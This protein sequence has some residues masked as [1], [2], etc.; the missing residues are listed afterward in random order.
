MIV[1][2]MG[3]SPCRMWIIR[4]GSGVDG[5]SPCRMWIIRNGRG[6]DGGGA[7]SHVDYKK[8]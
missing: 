7:M 8:W 6:V 5:G 2:W 3:G 1:G 4:N